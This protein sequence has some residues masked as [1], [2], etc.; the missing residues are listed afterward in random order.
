MV[1]KRKSERN[2]I[3]SVLRKY[4]TGPG[5][6]PKSISKLTKVPI[7]NVYKRIYDLREY[8]VIYTNYRMIKG[9]RKA[10]YRLSD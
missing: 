8:H 3:E 4:N 9:Q 2:K 10:F 7:D 1:K 6:S 5:V